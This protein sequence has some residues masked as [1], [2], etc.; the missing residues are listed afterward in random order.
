MDAYI[1]NF[2]NV[3]GLKVVYAYFPQNR[4]YFLD[5]IDHFS[6]WNFSFLLKNKESKTVLSKIKSF[7]EMNDA[8]T[9]FQTD[10]G[11]E[12]KNLNLKIYLENKNIIYI[13]ILPYHPQSNGCSEAIHKEIKKYLLD[14]L[15]KK[16]LILI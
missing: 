9:F 12:F 7:I 11:K 4:V 10:N 3:R 6:K 1:F 8:P 13:Q 5:C 14:D 16:N 15:A 2:Q